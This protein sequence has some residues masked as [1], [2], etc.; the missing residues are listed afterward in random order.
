MALVPLPG[1]GGQPVPLGAVGPAGPGRG[2][3]WTLNLPVCFSADHLLRRTHGGLLDLLPSRHPRTLLALPQ[4]HPGASAGPGGAGARSRFPL[5]ALMDHSDLEELEAFID[6]YFETVWEHSRG[7]PE[8]PE[9]EEQSDLKT[10]DEEVLRSI[11][12]K[13]SKL[14]LLEDLQ[15]ELQELRS[16]L[17]HSGKLTEELRERK[18]DGSKT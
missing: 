2:L 13:L 4:T 18:H 17:E 7:S 9:L 3:R 6:L 15:K 16:S 12:R 1:S 11:D 5:R 10:G 14:E 8:L